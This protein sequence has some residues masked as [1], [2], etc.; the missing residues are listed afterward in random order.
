MLSRRNGQQKVGLEYR[1]VM[2]SADALD[3]DLGWTLGVVFR[4]YVR[5]AN[6]LMSHLPGGPRGYQVLAAA[7]QELAGGQ[8][9]L[10]Q[11]LGIDKTVM[12]YLV[13]DLEEAGLVR[14]QP[15]PT[16]R[17]NKRIVATARGRSTWQRTQTRLE[18]AEDHLL[19]PLDAADRAVLRALLRRLAVQA[20]STDPVTDTC[21]IVTELAPDEP[22]VA[23]GTR[24][25]RR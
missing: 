17:R 14:R 16:D 2:H 19:A 15:D 22:P 23:V 1:Q 8:G 10:A 20:Q 3:G 5:T 11:R 24:R 25:P 21:H 13:D 7:A 9:A 6:T 4:S 18:Q 12:T